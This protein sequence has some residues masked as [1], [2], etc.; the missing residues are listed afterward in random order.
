MT[1]RSD[2]QMIQTVQRNRTLMV[3]ARAASTVNDHIGEL[4]IS[5]RLSRWKRTMSRSWQPFAIAL[6]FIAL[7]GIIFVVTMNRMSN[8]DDFL[9]IWAAVGPIVGVVTGLVPTYF[10]HNSA[11]DAS[12][13]A[14]TNAAENG[15]LKGMMQMKGLDPETGEERRTAPN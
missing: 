7:V 3:V 6:A 13:R 8:V 12:A 14:E 2:G 5:L 11:R 4:M 10:F 9:K 1:K 15:R